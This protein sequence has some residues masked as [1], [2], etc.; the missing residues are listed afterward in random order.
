[1]VL[2]QIELMQRHGSRKT[3]DKYEH[4]W[5]EKLIQNLDSIPIIDCKW[6]KKSNCIN[7]LP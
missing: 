5:E 3:R 7:S 2:C 1:M 4:G 6:K